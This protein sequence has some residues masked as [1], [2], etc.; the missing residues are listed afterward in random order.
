HHVAGHEVGVAGA[1]ERTGL[2]H[3]PGAR[4]DVAVHDHLG[5]ADG[6]ARDGASIAA[7]HDGAAEHVIGQAPAHVIVD[8]HLR[9]VGQAG[10]EIAGRATDVQL[11]LVDETDAYV[12]AGIGIDDLD[13]LAVGSVFADQLI[14]LGDGDP[15]QIDRRH[16]SNVPGGGSLV[17]SAVPGKSRLSDTSSEAMAMRSSFSNLTIGFTA[18]RSFA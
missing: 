17:L 3:L 9:T 15:A 6:H 10:T 2:H 18:S 14:G 5:A 4:A 1:A 16:V 11:H 13:V 7:H 12:M 8:Q